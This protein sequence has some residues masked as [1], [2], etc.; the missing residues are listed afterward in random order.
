MEVYAWFGCLVFLFCVC[1]CVCVCV[2]LLI[3]AWPVEELIKHSQGDNT[4]IAKKEIKVLFSWLPIGAPIWRSPTSEWLQDG[5]TSM[6]KSSCPDD[7]AGAGATHLRKA[8]GYQWSNSTCIFYLYE[9]QSTVPAGPVTF[10]MSIIYSKPTFARKYSLNL[11]YPMR[12]PNYRHLC[13]A[14]PFNH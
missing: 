6:M 7:C 12:L 2:F 9:M 4:E 14:P 5:D 8:S 13:S 11:I 1:V 10:Q 3:T